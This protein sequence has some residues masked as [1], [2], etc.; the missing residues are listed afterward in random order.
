LGRFVLCARRSWVRRE[1]LGWEGGPRFTGR[2][3]KVIVPGVVREEVEEVVGAVEGVDVVVDEVVE[4]VEVVL[5]VVLV[6]DACGRWGCCCW[7]V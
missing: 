1:V 7:G 5:A 2:R 6:L 3:G 4:V